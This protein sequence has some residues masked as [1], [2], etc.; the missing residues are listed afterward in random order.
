MSTLSFEDFANQV[1]QKWLTLTI[2]SS[3]NPLPNLK[4]SEFCGS[5][6]GPDH[7]GTVKVPSM[8]ARFSGPV[9]C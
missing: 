8:A 6:A 3:K 4:N 7:A 9:R 5:I 2:S 1:S